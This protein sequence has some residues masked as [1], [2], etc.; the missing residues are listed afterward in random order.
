MPLWILYQLV[1]WLLGLT[2]VLVRRDLSKDAELLGTV[3]LGEAGQ[4]RL[5]IPVGQIAR[6][7]SSKTARTR[8]FTTSSAP[9]S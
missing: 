4:M 2:A 5:L 1:R 7:S 9:S 3:A 6:V 8:R